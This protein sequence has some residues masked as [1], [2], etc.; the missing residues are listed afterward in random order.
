MEKPVNGQL[1]QPGGLPEGWRRPEAASRLHVEVNRV[2]RALRQG[3]AAFLRRHSGLSLPEWRVLAVL[4]ELGALAQKDVVAAAFME[5]AS[6][7]L[8]RLRAAGLVQDG[9]S[10]GDGRVR[11][12]ALAPE[13]AALVARLRPLL[14]AR[15]DSIDGALSP[16]EQE[17]FIAALA[18]IAAAAGQADAT[19]PTARQ[20][21]VTE[22]EVDRGTRRA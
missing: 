18:R 19:P 1:M 13:G 22:P 5:Q 10:P 2:H 21:R 9:R 14:Q 4:E 3:F 20:E 7:A 17:A 6:K 16:D 15:R 8:T 12:C 11:V